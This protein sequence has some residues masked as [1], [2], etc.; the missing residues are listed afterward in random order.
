MYILPIILSEGKL[1]IAPAHWGI[2]FLP[3]SRELIES[4][5]QFNMKDIKHVFLCTEFSI[6]GFGYVKNPFEIVCEEEAD[7]PNQ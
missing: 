6:D 2:G 3:P 7:R 1:Y 4:E 5:M